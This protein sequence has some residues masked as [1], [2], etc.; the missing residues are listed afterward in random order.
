MAAENR[1]SQ[2]KQL[3]TNDCEACEQKEL[4]PVY[5]GQSCLLVKE[6]LQDTSAG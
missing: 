4:C 3:I 2:E 5:M 6:R 1:H